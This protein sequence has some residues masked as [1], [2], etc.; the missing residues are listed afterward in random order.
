MGVLNFKS[1]KRVARANRKAVTKREFSGRVLEHE[2]LPDGYAYR[3]STKGRRVRHDGGDDIAYRNALLDLLAI[4]MRA[5]AR[6]RVIDTGAFNLFR[7]ERA[8]V[9]RLRRKERNANL[10]ARAA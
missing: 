9:K 3:H 4:S 10:A 8:K 6:E 5:A 1:S 7:I 2:Q